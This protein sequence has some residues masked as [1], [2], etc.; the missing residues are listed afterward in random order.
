MAG[1]VFAVWD[2]Y[3]FGELV[4]WAGLPRGHREPLRLLEAGIQITGTLAGFRAGES[5]V[6]AI[7]RREHRSDASGADATRGGSPHP[8]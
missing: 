4:H 2:H 3:V 8:G 6:T 7:V 1:L 5:L